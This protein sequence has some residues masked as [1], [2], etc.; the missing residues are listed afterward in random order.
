[1]PGKVGHGPVANDLVK[2]EQKKRQPHSR[3]TLGARAPGELGVEDH[4]CAEI[5]GRRGR[6]SMGKTAAGTLS[7][8]PCAGD[9]PRAPL[10]GDAHGPADVGVV[11]Q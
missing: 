5:A 8:H 7:A 10:I 1:M 6:L 2:M 11:H 3:E 4:D 9:A